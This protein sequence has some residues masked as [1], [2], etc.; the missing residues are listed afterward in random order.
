M[1]DSEVP[2]GPDGSHFAPA[3]QPSRRF[4]ASIHHSPDDEVIGRLRTT[5]IKLRTISGRWVEQ[6]CQ[7]LPMTVIPCTS[8]DTIGSTVTVGPPARSSRELEPP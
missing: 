5:L 4:L 1:G 6:N 2:P 3:N 8:G 7:K